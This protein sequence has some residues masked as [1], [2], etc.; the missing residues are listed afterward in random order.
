MWFVCVCVCVRGFFDLHQFDRDKWSSIWHR[1]PM[2]L[3][4]TAPVI[5]GLI[6]QWVPLSRILSTRLEC[7]LGSWPSC[8]YSLTGST[9]FQAWDRCICYWE[10]ERGVI[11]VVDLSPRS[12]WMI[13]TEERR[14]GT[15]EDEIM[16]NFHPR[17]WYDVL[18]G[19]ELSFH[20]S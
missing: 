10:I 6:A 5:L 20:C 16:S 8:W 15:T 7:A 17:V 11:K 14:Q 9:C 12:S 13:D 4:T 2:T 19:R 1:A 18:V 3:I